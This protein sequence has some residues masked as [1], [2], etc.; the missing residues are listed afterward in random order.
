MKRPPQGHPV[1]FQAGA[2]EASKVLAARSAE[3]MFTPLHSLAGAQAFYRDVKGRLAAHGREPDDLKIMPGLNPI[4][5]RTMA[6]AEEKHR[7]LQTLI[8]PDVGLELL[9]NAVGGYDLSRFDLDGP[10]PEEVDATYKPT[11][12]VSFKNVLQ[13]A[14]EEHL[15][16][17]QLYQRFGGARGQRTIIGTGETIAAQMA[18]WFESYGCDGFLIQPSHLPG[19]LN[20]FVAMVI[21]ELQER[22]VFRTEYEGT[23]LR[24]HLGLKRPKSRYAA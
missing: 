19:G 15:T 2:S 22:G 4:V 12:S 6:E 20:E 18:E 13:W 8:H 23:M 24:D 7:Y 14:R 16:I 9:S 5:G 21:P 17:R 3:A 1:F 10:L 11:D